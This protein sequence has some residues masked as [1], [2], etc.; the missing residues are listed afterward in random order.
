MA[1]G[2]VDAANAA[3]VVGIAATAYEE[4]LSV[5]AGGAM[6]LD[7]TT[8]AVVRAAVGI[9]T[10]AYDDDEEAEEATAAA[11]A[12]VAAGGGGAAAVA[13]AIVVRDGGITTEA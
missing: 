4:E 10:D 7:E 6:A 8:A 3:R 5:G 11:A 13:A 9:A 12:G 1:G 2:V